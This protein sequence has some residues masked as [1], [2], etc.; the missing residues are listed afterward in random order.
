MVLPPR[1]YTRFG[2][3]GKS[4]M[5]GTALSKCIQSYLDRVDGKVARSAVGKGQRRWIRQSNAKAYRVE[6]ACGWLALVFPPA[7]ERGC[8]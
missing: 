5:V 1:S 7:V 2:E 8:S 3:D 4:R 6:R